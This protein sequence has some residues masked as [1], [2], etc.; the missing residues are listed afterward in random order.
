VNAQIE[1]EGWRLLANLERVD[2]GLRTKL[3]D[4]LLERIKR[5]PK[6]PA[7]L[8]AIGRFGARVPLYGPLSSVVPPAVAERWL[9]RLPTLRVWIPDTADALIRIAALTEDPARDVEPRI[10]EAVLQRLRE[11]GCN[12]ETL[13][14]L[15]QVRPPSPREASR[16][17][18]ES[19]PEGLQLEAKDEVV[20][21]R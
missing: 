17:F 10:R 18:G 21:D 13:A 3:G 11:W 14:A 4:E 2:A 20:G 6:N 7:W 19:L 8:W 12:D 16:T 5:E 15:L 1:R 9:D